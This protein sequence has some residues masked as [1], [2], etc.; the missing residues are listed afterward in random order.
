MPKRNV[1]VLGATGTVGQRIIQMLENHPWFQLAQVAASD[2]SEGKS[3]EEA[4]KGRWLLA[5]GIPDY[6]RKMRVMPCTTDIDSELVF[7][8][9]DSSVAGPIEEDFANA[10]HYVCS[11]CRNHRMEP[12]VPL[13]IPEVNPAHLKIL[14]I[15]KR[16][17]SRSGYIV[18]DPNCSTIGLVLALKPLDDAYGAKRVHVVTMQAISGAGYPGV[19]SLD[20]TD[21]VIP[22][23]SG[24]EEK[25]ETETQK[26]LGSVGENGFEYSRIEVGAQCNR[27]PVVDGH[28]ECVFLDVERKADV[29]EAIKMLEN[30]RG[31]PQ[32]L[33]LPTAPERPI[34]VMRDDNRPQPRLDR[35]NGTERSAGMTVYVGRFR[36]D[37]IFDYRFVVLSHNTIRGAAGAAILNAELLEAQGYMR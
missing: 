3:Y 1:A 6:V 20:I 27:V 24:E 32:D 5:G 16:A 15:Q 13:V 4:V 14:E 19:A 21:N 28:E 8:A 29:Q 35:Y 26:I 34:V 2:R 33:K 23:I 7:S 10:G 37:K 22:F 17:K 11:N 9:L 31:V 18:T 25:M 36:E 30:Y 12:Y